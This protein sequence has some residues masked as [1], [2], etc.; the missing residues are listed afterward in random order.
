MIKRLIPLLFLWI[1][2]CGKPPAPTTDVP[3]RIIST[4]PNIT[5]TLHDMH[6]EE[7]L[8]GI[9]SFSPE[10]RTGA[11]PIVGD[12]LNLNYEQV[13][14]LRPD[15]VI[16]ERS[17][18]VQKSRLESLGIPYLETGS[19]TLSDIL[20]SVR[21]IGDAC[22][23]SKQADELIAQFNA[24]LKC[25]ESE[26]AEHP[27]TLIVFGDFSGS[28]RIEQLYAMGSDCIHSELLMLAGGA[29]VVSDRRPS[30]MLSREGLL[31]I[32]PEVIIELTTGSPGNNWQS[33]DT[34]DAVRNDHVYILDGPHTC[35][36]SPGNLIR[37][38][39]D[40]SRIMKQATGAQ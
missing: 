36:P 26:L 20:A 3:Q 34:I 40:F 16:L 18:D 1:A 33:V 31:R 10:D 4:A 21:A 7:R 12:F 8:V 9:S 13:V 32:N 28:G 15:L 35:I 25:D 27:R 39:Q 24:E 30:I 22:G 29:N 17:A 6:L 14:A 2:G 5:A 37:T 38:L 23:T 19:L 11:I